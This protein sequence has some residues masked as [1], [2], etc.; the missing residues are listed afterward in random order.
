MTSQAAG[1]LWARHA[2]DPH[3]GLIEGCLLEYSAGRWT[4]V[5]R[6]SCPPAGADVLDRGLLTP[7]LLNAHAHLD[8]SFLAGRLSAA[9]GFAHWL[10]T[11]VA[12]RRTL[13]AETFALRHA[14]AAEAARAMAAAGTTE[15]WDV[16]AL[17]WKSAEPPPLRVL[18]FVE[19]LAPTPERW[20]VEGALR[21]AAWS[22]RPADPAGIPPGLSPHSTYT[23]VPEA[24]AL[25]AQ[26]AQRT[27]RP[28]AIHLAESPEE[29]EMLVD[30]RGPL[31]DLLS[32]LAGRELRSIFGTRAT[33]IRRAEHAGLLGPDTIAIHCNLP[34]PDEPGLLAESG[35]IVAWCPRSHAFFGYPAYPLGD[36]MRAGVRLALGTDSLASN[37][38]LDIRAEARAAAATDPGV[39]PSRWL[40]L[41]TG[42]LTGRRGRFAPG[43]PADAVLWNLSAMPGSAATDEWAAA[44]LDP[45]ARVESV[46]APA[47]FGATA[48]RSDAIVDAP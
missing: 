8:Y 19:I 9:G 47:N 21:L 17:G 13:P 28:L 29:I 4:H 16:Q 11:M 44:W 6:A 3:E 45:A 32:G 48:A 40:A 31:H 14:A 20:A 15:V 30:G 38:V 34:A 42:A 26:A 7:G 41:A 37:D 27:G 1:R 22:A 36:Y 24:L 18:P 2:L 10:G 12:V 25:C 5:A 33:P 35:A 43:M 23:V 39:P 46:L